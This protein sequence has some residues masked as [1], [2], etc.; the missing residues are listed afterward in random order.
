MKKRNLL[1]IS[2]LLLAVLMLSA[3]AGE[4]GPAGPAGEQGPAGPAGS[5]GAAGSEGA[6]AGT[7][8]AE[9]VTSAVCGTCHTETYDIFMRSGHPYK[10]TKVVD[11]QAPTYPFT[12]IKAV[13]EGYT[14]DDIS[15]VIGGYNWK[16]RFVDL[17]G[18]I[19]TGADENA[20]TQYNF[21]ND[22]LGM[23]DN[24]VGYHA[25]EVEKPYSCGTCHTTG[26]NPEGHQDDL[27]GMVGTFSEG[28]VHC[29]ECHGPGS[30]HVANPYGV[31]LKVD[32]DSA[33]CGDCH[34]RGG[35]E[36]VNA[37]GGFIKHHE[38]YEELFQSKHITMDCVTCHDPHT[39]VIQLR[40]DG[41]P[42]TLTTCENCHYEEAQVQAVDTHGSFVECIDCHMPRITKSALGNADVFSG[43]LRTHIMAIDPEQVGQF[44]EDGSTSLSQISL[45][46]ACRSCHSEGGM[47]TDKADEVLID[48]ASEYHTAP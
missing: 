6:A 11:G 18:Y 27:P 38:Q 16:A 2:I 46:F 25:G 10:L 5:D 30:L 29:E 1:I 20:T 37:S 41:L 39:G 24:W 14:W 23:G 36:A 40:K 13:P 48:A 42:T 33:A 21:Y 19:I 12:E 9:Y 34:V 28:G 17:D 8:G 35:F 44:S 32:R 43:D 22:N 26:Y 4:Q 45:D 3:C 31:A 15:Y 47:A 7:F